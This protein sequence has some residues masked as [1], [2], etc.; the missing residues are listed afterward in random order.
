MTYYIGSARHDENGRYAKGK[1]GDQTG[2]EVATQTFYDYLSKGGWI[3]YRFKDPYAAVA[4][5]NAMLYACSNNHIGYSQ[6]DRY[7][8]IRN[9][10]HTKKDTNADCSTLIRACIIAA[11]NRDVGDFTTASEGAALT[12]SGLFD[13]IGRVN[14]HSRLY[15]GD[16]LVTARKGHTAAV[17]TGLDRMDE[18]V[19]SPK[20]KVAT[21]RNDGR[22]YATTFCSEATLG[23]STKVLMIKVLQQALNLDYDAGLTIDGEY[24]PKTDKALGSHYV[25]F[26][27]KQYLVSAAEIF[28]YLLGFNPHG[29]EVPGIYGKGLKEA[30]SRSKL[31]ADWFRKKVQ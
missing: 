30:T 12:N 6:S 21:T 17:T 8:V 13:C 24:G 11:C 16:I 19:E 22:K 28:C 26:K 20:A 7:G 9:T 18:V 2:N 15:D 1:A 23:D 5:K 29:F 3:C 4:M 27:E 14:K 31:D 25:K 10:I